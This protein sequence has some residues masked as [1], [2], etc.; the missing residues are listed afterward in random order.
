[1]GMQL[2]KVYFLVLGCF[3]WNGGF[4]NQARR[5]AKRGAGATL[6]PRQLKGTADFRVAR[7]RAGLQAH[8]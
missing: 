4:A 1:M 5:G 6:N 3:Q 2:K 7:I 8:P